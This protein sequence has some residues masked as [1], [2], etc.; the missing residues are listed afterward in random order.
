MKGKYEADDDVG[1]FLFTV[2]SLKKKKNPSLPPSQMKKHTS[3]WIW[4]FVGSWGSGWREVKERTD[5]GGGGIHSDPAS[6]L[7]CAPGQVRRLSRQLGGA[8]DRK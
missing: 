8:E 7:L 1:L 6:G 5:G 2:F 3:S 4:H